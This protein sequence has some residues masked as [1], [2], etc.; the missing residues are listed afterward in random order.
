MT[1]Q[2]QAA[3]SLGSPPGLPGRVMV[4]DN[5]ADPSTGESTT[6]L[7]VPIDGVEVKLRELRRQLAEAEEL[8]REWAADFAQKNRRDAEDTV[9][10]LSDI[11][12]AMVV[13]PAY[14]LVKFYEGSPVSCPV[15]ESEPD[16]PESL[17]ALWQ[18]RLDFEAHIVLSG[19]KDSATTEPESRDIEESELELVS[20]LPIKQIFDR[21]LNPIVSVA[22]ADGSLQMLIELLNA[23]YGLK[24]QVNSGDAQAE[25]IDLRQAISVEIKALPLNLALESIL[26][27]LGLTFEF[28]ADAVSVLPP[29][30]SGFKQAKARELLN[31][32]AMQSFWGW[33]EELVRLSLLAGTLDPDN[34]LARARAQSARVVEHLVEV[35]RKRAPDS[36]DTGLTYKAY[37][38]A[39]LI[40]PGLT[41]SRAAHVAELIEWLTGV[42]QPDTWQAV[43]GSA[44]VVYYPLDKTLIIRQHDKVHKEVAKALAMVRNRD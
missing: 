15:E 25:G 43:G 12:L 20:S 31:R 23:E 19:G 24:I 11:A 14:W 4:A 3:R 34:K 22:L 37:D 40:R 27:P 32:C 35:E 29:Q 9:K 5:K 10:P 17:R 33:N 26:F 1:R 41:G 44:T 30:P 36:V 21:K 18:P 2:L 16:L 7:P 42:V 8:N 6:G 28:R 13:A 38:V 39:D